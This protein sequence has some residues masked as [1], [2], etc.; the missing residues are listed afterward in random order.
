MNLD[1]KRVCWLDINSS[2][3][4][5]SLALPAIEAQQPNNPNIEWCVVSGTIN[6]VV[7]SIVEELN[8]VNPDIIAYTAWLFN[9]EMLHNILSRYKKL[10]PNVVIIGGGPEYL[11]CNAEYLRNYKYVDYIIR[12]EGEIAF[13]QWFEGDL[14]TKGLCYVDDND[15]Y[16]DNG[17]ARVDDFA[18]LH[19]P[20]ESKFFSWDKPFVQLESARGCFNSCSFCVSG[21]DKPLR[22]IT[23]DTLR[24]RLNTIKEHNIKDIRVLDRTFNGNTSRT[25][26]LLSLFKEFSDDMH[27]H[28]E[29]H[30]A[31]MNPT[32]RE[33]LQA[34][35]HGT[36]HLE[37]GVQSLSQ[38]VLDE[39]TRYGKLDDVIDGLKFLSSLDNLEVHSDL[40]AGLPHYSLDMIYDDV[41]TL[42][43]IGCDEIQLELLK[44]LPGTSIR[45]RDDIIYSPKSPYEV[46]QTEWASYSELQEARRLS[47]V[48]DL[49][50]NCS[51]WRN[52]FR[53]LIGIDSLFLKRYTAY[54]TAL[55]LVDTPL[56]QERRGLIIYN[57][58]KDNHPSALITVTVDWLGAGLSLKK[59][60][61]A[62]AIQR[63]DSDIAEIAEYESSNSR[64]YSITIENREIWFVV[65]R[66]IS[67]TQPIKIFVK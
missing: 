1:K 24:N 13:Y 9:H 29:V 56:S 46:M 63:S 28:L 40:I 53:E 38:R 17:L 2:Y 39:V 33:A 36:L 43:Q 21:N 4:H 31:L 49:Y 18:S 50:Y 20:E 30:P 67:L 51:S 5:S 35:P 52:T 26:E 16:I 65:D 54:I 22:T 11:G 3:S 60:A 10:N 23:I 48:I 41:V 19:F 59:G 12:G 8:S 62:L 25:L 66:G 57:Y 15:T 14:S 47:R 37:A 34:M 45:E 6:S 7:S 27:F 58:I 32:L 61:G 42:S 64:T 44:L 55:E